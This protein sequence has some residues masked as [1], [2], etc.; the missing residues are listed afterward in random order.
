MIDS[1]APSCYLLSM[2]VVHLFALTC[3]LFFTCAVRAGSSRWQGPAII[4]GHS[5]EQLCAKHHQPLERVTV[6]GP[7]D[8]VCVLV[9]P[10]KAWTRQQARSPNALPFALHRKS[11]LLYSRAVPMSYCARCEEEVQGA[12][13]EYGPKTKTKAEIGRLLSNSLPVLRLGRD[14][15]GY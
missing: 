9:Q 13:R 5:G 12:I 7:G 15:S 4:T 8:G 14:P 1:S 11:S 10:S 3:L 6:F 2:R